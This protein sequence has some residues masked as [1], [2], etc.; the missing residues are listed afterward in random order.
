MATLHLRGES[1][2][3]GRGMGAENRNYDLYWGEKP[4]DFSGL[5]LNFIIW[6]RDYCSTCVVIALE[7]HSDIT[8]RGLLLALMNMVSVYPV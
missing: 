5:S 6:L 8:L 4:A 7:Q 2:R 3:S 1:E